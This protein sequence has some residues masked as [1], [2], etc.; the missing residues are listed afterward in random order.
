MGKDRAWALKKVKESVRQA[1]AAGVARVAVGLEDASRSDISFVREVGQVAM[2]A[3]AF[4]LRL[5]DTVGV[6]A[7]GDILM[8][9]ESMAGLNIELAVHCHNDFGMATANTITALDNGAVWG[10]AT[11]LGLGERAGNSRLEEILAFLVLQKKTG[12]YDLAGLPALSRMVA[13]ECGLSIAGSRPIIGSDLFT[14]ET[15]IHV[16]GIMADP[17]TYEPFDPEVLGASRTLL[18]GAQAG[19]R[20]VLA[21]LTRLGIPTPNKPD[22]ARITRKVRALAASRKCSLEDHEI[23]ALLNS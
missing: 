11:L 17:S 20:S 16:H 18:V 5:A 7:P 12:K 6:C 22:L 8:L 19:R 23:M 13:R 15:G 14:C 10:D 3:G 21:T 2:E 4:R 1:L 9:L